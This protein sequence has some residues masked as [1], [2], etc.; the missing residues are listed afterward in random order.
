MR[1]RGNARQ[2]QANIPR[3][4]YVLRACAAAGRRAGVWGSGGADYDIRVWET[5]QWRV[6]QATWRAGRC[7]VNLPALT[8]RGTAGHWHWALLGFPIVHP[9][10]APASREEMAYSTI[11]RPTAGFP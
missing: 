5:G 11:T 9:S 10:R 4:C 3:K 7:S 2:P 8:Y 6:K 1:H